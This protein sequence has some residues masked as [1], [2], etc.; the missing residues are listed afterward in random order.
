MQRATKFTNTMFPRRNVMTCFIVDKV[1]MNLAVPGDFR[2]KTKRFARPIKKLRLDSR[3]GAK[4][5]TNFS[6]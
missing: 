1:F 6:K 3:V 4:Q 2:I 5:E